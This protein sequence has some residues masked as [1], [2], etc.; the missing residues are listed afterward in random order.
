MVE[1]IEAVIAADGQKSGRG[2]TPVQHF[3][4]SFANPV[5]VRLVAA[6]VEGQHQDEPSRR[7]FRRGALRHHP[8]GR[9]NG[10]NHQ[11]TR[12]RAFSLLRCP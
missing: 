8:K 1:C 10:H 9:E 11:K 7:R 4:D 5:Q 6:I 2:K 3:R 12:I